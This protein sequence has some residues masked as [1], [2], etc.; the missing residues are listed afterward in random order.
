MF[1]W[2]AFI[3][4]LLA[5]IVYYFG[6]FLI[7]KLKIDDPLDAVA[8]ICAF[9]QDPIYRGI[10]SVGHIV[11]FF[12]YWLLVSMLERLFRQMKRMNYAGINIV[13]PYHL[14]HLSHYL[15]HF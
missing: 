3:T 11:I 15:S 6:A 8:G 12:K 13:I 9:S 10:E 5:A 4:G 7:T 1:M 2:G 14:F